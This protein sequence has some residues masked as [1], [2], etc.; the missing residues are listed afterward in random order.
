MRVLALVV[1]IMCLWTRP[2]WAE[3]CEIGVFADP[4]GTISLVSPTEASDFSVYVIIFAEDT[5]AAAAYRMMIGPE[6]PYGPFLMRRYTGPGRMGLSIDEPEGTNSALAECVIGFGGHPVIVDEYVFVLF[7]GHRGR[8]EFS[9]EPNVNQ[10][11]DSPIYVTC[12]DV[13]RNCDVGSDLRVPLSADARSFGA[14]KSLYHK[15]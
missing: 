2:V 11:P 14:I 8:L 9:I 4:E 15:D 7:S 1:A 6:D 13:I 3:Q 5:V 10:N 12:N